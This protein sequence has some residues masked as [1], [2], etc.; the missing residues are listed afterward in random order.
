MVRNKNKF[1]GEKKC[2][3]VACGDG[4]I[5]LQRQAP[6]SLSWLTDVTMNVLEVQWSNLRDA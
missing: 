2:L 4:K 5:E 6:L 3:Y 1:L